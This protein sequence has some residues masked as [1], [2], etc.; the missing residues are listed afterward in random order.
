MQVLLQGKTTFWLQVARGIIGDVNEYIF[1]QE[2]QPSAKSEIMRSQRHVA[3]AENGDDTQS[4]LRVN[5]DKAAP[6]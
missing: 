4:R 3:E 6:M 2:T 1:T 5:T